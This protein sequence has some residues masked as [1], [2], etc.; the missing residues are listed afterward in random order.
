[1]IDNGTDNV[2]LLLRRLTGFFNHDNLTETQ[3]SFALNFIFKIIKDNNCSILQEY[4]DDT[5]KQPSFILEDPLI[6][7][8]FSDE[9][10]LAMYEEFNELYK[11]GI[12]F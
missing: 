3:K 12:S 6:F 11:Y 7:I 8:L 4:V 2:L 1:M 9:K 10:Y 5:A